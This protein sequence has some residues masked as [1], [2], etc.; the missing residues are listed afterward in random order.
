MIYE[1]HGHIIADGVSYKDSMQRHKNGVDKKYVRRALE[2]VAGCG[3]GFY[4]DGGDKYM[5]SA[6]AKTIAGEYGIDYRTPGCILHK[7]GYYGS[8][9][10]R[11][12]DD[13]AGFR[14]RVDEAKEHGADFIKTTVTGMLDFENGGGIMGP[15]LSAGELKEAVRIAE[16]EG[17]RVMA[18]VNGAENIKK[19]LEAGVSSIEHGFWPDSSVIDYFLQTGAVWVPTCA[20]AYNLIGSGR[21]ADTV[22]HKVFES[23]KSILIEA[24]GRGVLIASG[25]D[26]GAWNVPQGKGTLDEIAILREM[27][28][29]PD[30]ANRAIEKR[31]KR[32]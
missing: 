7:K 9:Y 27:G 12:Y 13:M 18:H 15:V 24:Y 20:T 8:M 21:Y 11:S 2:T 32:G 28:I 25:S 23:Q 19:A 31:F 22:M 3:V 14:A 17:F 30:K 6:F 5:V 4:R 10:G 16:G 26:C 1:C 29:D